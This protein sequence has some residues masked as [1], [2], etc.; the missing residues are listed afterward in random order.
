MWWED[1]D[2]INAASNEENEAPGTILEKYKS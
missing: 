1:D 2:A